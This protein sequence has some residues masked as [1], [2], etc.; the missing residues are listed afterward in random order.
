MN[1]IKL[2]IN[3]L[4]KDKKIL[5]LSLVLA[6]ITTIV[7]GVV[8]AA[9]YSNKIQGGISSSVIRFHCLANSNSTADQTLKLEVRD[10]VLAEIEPM[11]SQSKSKEETVE[12]LEKSIN[13]MRQVALQ[14]VKENGKDY[15]VRVSLENCSFPMKNYGDAVFPAGN[16][17]ALRVE[18]GAAEGK[19][20]WCVVF[21][22]LCFVD[23][24]CEQLDSG[25][26]EELKNILTQ[27]EYS[28]IVAAENDEEIVPEIKFKVVEWWQE[29]KAK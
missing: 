29:R 26:K 13:E 11:V 18:I 10:R 19:N 9:Q 20:F 12:I 2:G 22:P 14:T 5:L 23:E 24:G 3:Q 15:D 17:D 4:K 1:I 25:T 7:F 27:E 6:F 28:I 8:A 16:Y 21:P